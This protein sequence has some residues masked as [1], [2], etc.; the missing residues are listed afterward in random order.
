MPLIEPPLFG[1]LLRGRRRRGG[2]YRLGFLGAGAGVDEARSD[3]DVRFLT[4]VSEIGPQR[5]RHG[6]LEH[7]L[8]HLLIDGAE[9]WNPRRRVFRHLE[10]DESLASADGCSG[11]ASLEHEGPV[12]QHL[13]QLAV[14]AL[15]VSV[16]IPALVRIR[17]VGIQLDQVLEL[18]S[19]LQLGNDVVGFGLRLRE[20]LVGRVVGRGDKYLAEPF[21][22]RLRELLLV[23]IVVGLLDRKSVV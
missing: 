6:F 17:T 11:L 19:R 2:V 18:G 7:R 16:E 20:L 14:A 15:V 3:I 5:G 22:L 21:G 8:L 1:F 12:L 9:G 23:L 4:E 13:C 10:D